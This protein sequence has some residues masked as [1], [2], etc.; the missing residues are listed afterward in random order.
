MTDSVSS[1]GKRRSRPQRRYR[2]ERDADGL[3]TRLVWLGDFVPGPELSACPRCGSA[4]W[5][6][7]RC[8]DCWYHGDAPP[9]VRLR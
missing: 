3:P 5:L 2:I 4:R 7:R 8:L 6:D 1:S 9:F